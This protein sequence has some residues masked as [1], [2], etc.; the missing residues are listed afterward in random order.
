M[1]DRVTVRCQNDHVPTGRTWSPDG[2]LSQ[3]IGIAVQLDGR[4]RIRSERGPVPR[5]EKPG[6]SKLAE[7]CGIAQSTLQRYAQGMRD[8]KKLA[9]TLADLSE[10]AEF[11]NVDFEWLVVGRGSRE[12]KAG[13]PSRATPATAQDVQRIV[14]EELDRRGLDAPESSPRPSQRPRRDP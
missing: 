6:I 7:D 13:A 11:L 12:R 14:S 10:L 5:A 8:E 1:S 3:R 9:A 4:Y 2:T